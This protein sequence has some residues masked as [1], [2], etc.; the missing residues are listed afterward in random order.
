MLARARF[1]P[2]LSAIAL[3]ACGPEAI[4]PVDDSAEADAINAELNAH[5]TLC[6]TPH[7]MS[8]ESSAV[9]DALNEFQN[10]AGDP[11]TTRPAGSV[12]VNVYVHVITR[13][14]GSGAVSAT[15]INNQIAV[16]ND[17]YAGGD[18][19]RASGQGSSAQATS[20]T[21]FRF[22]LAGT[23]TTAND[24]WYGMT[25]G[26]AA[27]QQAKTALRRGTARDL[28]IYS[29][30]IG[31]GLLGWATFPSDYNRSP[32]MDGVVVLNASFP[33][34]SAVPYDL[35]DTAT[36]EV[37]HWL[38]LYHTFQGGCTKNNDLVSDTPA[39]KSPFF[40]VP[41]P[42]TDTCSSSRYPGRDPVENFM[43][44]TDDV[45]MF[46]FTAGQSARMDAIVAQYRGL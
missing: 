16:L 41:P 22:V 24:S 38:G 3:A 14:N 40:G 39:E 35:G 8:A 18:T 4:D 12:T 10:R 28:N 33:G 26:S 6:G 34:G 43:D 23:D 9:Q 37:G 32:N 21:P 30:G 11:W 44:Y 7:P 5:P 31:Q 1:L 19:D 13:S 20:N 46:Q 27:E 36:H 42:Y 15:Q 29:A 17:A 25:M 45:A 2:L